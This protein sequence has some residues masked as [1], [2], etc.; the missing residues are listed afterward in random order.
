MLEGLIDS[1]G[2]EFEILECKALM[3]MDD[4]TASSDGS[5]HHFYIGLGARKTQ[6]FS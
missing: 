3:V 5:H 2:K 1:A 4:V 6:N